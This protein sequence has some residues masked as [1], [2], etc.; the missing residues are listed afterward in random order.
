[1]KIVFISDTHGQHKALNLPEGDILIHSGDFSRSSTIEELKSFNEWLGIL[2][3]KYKILI[4]GN[5]D[6]VLERFPELSGTIITNAIYL[7]DSEIIIEGLKIWGSPVTPNFYDWAFMKER[8]LELQEHWKK[9]PSKV[10][11]LITHGPPYG[12]LDKTF[13]GDF[14][15][16]EALLEVVKKIKPKIHV[17]GHIHEGYGIKR[18]LGTTFINTSSLNYHYELVND[19]IVLDI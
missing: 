1:M 4:A 14:A 17:F 5:H 9:V 10:D 6:L 16:C 8:G 15:G 12:I 3:Y 18:E 2:P 19:P 11:I 7:E 13:D